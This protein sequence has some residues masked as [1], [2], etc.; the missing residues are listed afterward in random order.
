MKLHYKGNCVFV[1]AAVP[2]PLISLRTADKQVIIPQ[3][4]EQSFFSL[5]LL[6]P[7][8]V[9]KWRRGVK[10]SQQRYSSRKTPAAPPSVSIENTTRRE[11]T[12]FLQELQGQ[13]F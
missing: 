12:R 11:N 10:R 1:V 2:I 13:I 9:C 5:E 7:K 8:H 4:C 3:E 6:W